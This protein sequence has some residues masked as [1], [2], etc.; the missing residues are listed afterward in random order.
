MYLYCNE[1]LNANVFIYCIRKVMQV[2]PSSLLFGVG[3]V[4]FSNSGFKRSFSKISLVFN[5]SSWSSWHNTNVMSF[6]LGGVSVTFGSSENI[7]VFLFWEVRI[8][9]SVSMWI[10]HWIISV[11]LPCWFGSQISWVTITPV[12]DFEVSNGFTSVVFWYVHCSLI[13]LV[14]DSFSSQ[15]PLSLFSESFKD[16]VWA[17]FHDWDFLVHTIFFASS[18]RACLVLSDFSI[19]TLWN[20]IGLQNHV[21]WVQHIWWAERT[22][23]MT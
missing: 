12:L 9:I 23:F 15:K 11:I 21:F 20:S 5:Y 10:L 6:V 13:G 16:M 22:I 4:D 2:G 7:L 19:A 1:A 18:G 8:I 3:C 17:N 14:V